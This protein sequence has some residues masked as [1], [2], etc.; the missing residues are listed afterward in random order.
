MQSLVAV[1]VRGGSI[2][3]DFSIVT[4][5]SITDFAK[6]IRELLKSGIP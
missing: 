4:P 6:A 5:G 2:S 1:R 3:D